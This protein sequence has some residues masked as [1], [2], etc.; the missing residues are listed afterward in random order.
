MDKDRRPH[1]LQHAVAAAPAAA[2]SAEPVGLLH[3]QGNWTQAE[4]RPDLLEE[5]LRKE[6]QNGWV[7]EF[8][9]TEEDARKQW[10]AGTP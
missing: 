8:P 5:L 6:V 4:Q 3:C 10:P 1:P 2:D 9:G 7:K